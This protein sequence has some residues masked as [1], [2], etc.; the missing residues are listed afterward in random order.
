LESLEGEDGYTPI[1]GVDYFD[2]KDG[3]DG[4]TPYIQDGYWYIDGANTGVK[5]EGVNGTNGA[6][7]KDGVNGADGKDG[8]NGQDGFSPIVSLS[9]TGSVATL[10]ITD[11]NGT[12]KVEIHDGKDGTGGGTT[13]PDENFVLS[14]DKVMYGNDTLSAVLDTYLFNVDYDTLLA[15]DASEIVINTTSTTSVLGQAILGQMVLA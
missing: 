1:K 7:G 5:A 14:S 2:G 13:T 9:K 8:T 15:F 12:Q 10:E 6:N 11:K 4:K 3:K